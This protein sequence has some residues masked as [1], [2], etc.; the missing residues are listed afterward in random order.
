MSQVYAQAQAASQAAVAAATA[1]TGNQ[2]DP[3][4]ALCAKMAAQTLRGSPP[5]GGKVRSVDELAEEAATAAGEAESDVSDEE[6]ASETPGLWKN[7][8]KIKK[9]LY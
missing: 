7:F 9:N 5:N 2:Q 8:I 4:A 6:D 3:E 1:P